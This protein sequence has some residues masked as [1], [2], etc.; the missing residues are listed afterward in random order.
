MM[1]A[2]N[3]NGLWPSWFAL[4]NH[5]SMLNIKVANAMMQDKQIRQLIISNQAT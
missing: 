4:E 1:H 5:H 2:A 3:C